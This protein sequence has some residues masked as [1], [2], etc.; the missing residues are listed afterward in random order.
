MELRQFIERNFNDCVNA[1]MCTNAGN[2][3]FKAPYQ[4]SL[5]GDGKPSFDRMLSTDPDHLFDLYTSIIH[6]NKASDQYAIIVELKEQ[7]T[8]L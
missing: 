2:I 5:G 7:I 4:N 3:P 8:S 1:M 6:D